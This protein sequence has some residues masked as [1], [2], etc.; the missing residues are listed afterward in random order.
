MNQTPTVLT[1]GA[2][3]PLCSGQ[4]LSLTSS[5]AAG[6][7]FNW[8]GPNGFSSTLQNPTI[9]NTT[10]LASGVYSVIASVSGCASATGTVSVLVNQTPIA[11]TA[12]GNSPI[13]SGQTL[14]LTSGSLPG[15][16]YSWSGPNSFTSTI[17]NPSIVNTTT[18]AS[19]VYSVFVTVSGC[20]SS[21]GTVN[22]VVNE[23]PSTPT[24]T[25][26]AP[27]CQGQTLFL[28]TSA[29]SGASY[30]WTGPNS[31]TSSIQNPTIVSTTTLEAGTYSLSITVLGCVSPTG[32]LNITINPTP[33]TPIA[34]SNAPLC[35]GQTLSLTAS[36]IFGANYSW[37][38]P[39][40]F[41][42]T[43]QN[44]V[45]TNATTS[46][47]GTYTV[48][49]TVAGCGSSTSTVSV[50]VSPLVI[51]PIANS[52]SPICEGQPILLNAGTIVGAT[53]N[54][55]GPNSFTSTVQNPSV[56]PT[57]TLSAGVYS[58]NA[59]VAGCTGPFGTVTVVVNPTPLPPNP[60]SNSPL[61]EGQTLLLT[62]SNIA[63]ATYNWSGP[64]SF[65]SSVQN[66]TIV[67]TTSLTAGV[68]TV[69]LTVGG[70]VSR[71][72]TINVIVNPLPAPVIAGANS[73][74]CVGATLSLT[75][76]NIIGATYSWNGPL[77]FTSAVQNPTIGGITL[78]ASGIYSVNV[79]VAGCTGSTG[80]VNVLVSPPVAAPVVGSNSPICEGQ[81]LFL[82]AGT[83]AGATY[84]WFGPNS[85]TS[86]VQNPTVITT[87][88]LSAGVYS[89]NA[90][91]AGCIGP[92]G[93]VTVIVNP[94]PAAPFPGS[95]S[96]ICAG[97]TLSLTTVSVAGATYSWTGPN[98]F[99]SNVQNPTISPTSTITSGTYTV[100]VNVGGCTSPDTTILVT[101]NPIPSAPT[102]TA[103]TPLCVNS[104]LSLTANSITGAVYNWTGPNSFTANIQNPT[105]PNA[106]TITVGVYS[107][108]IT[109]L[110]CTGPD[111]T[112]SVSVT[113]PAVVNAGPNDTICAGAMIITGLSGTITSGYI[114]QWTTL[115]S[116]TFTN[117]NSQTTDYNLSI[118]DTTAG[119]VTLVL[120]ATGGGCPDVSDTVVYTILSSP[121]VY[122]GADLNVCKNAVIPL[123]GIINGVTNTGFWISSGTGT[124]SPN[125]NSLIGTYFPSSSDTASNSIQL[126]L[127]ST[128][129]KGCLPDRD[130]LVV[131]FINAPKAS[132]TYTAACANLPI[133]F[134]NTSTPSLTALTH[135]WDFGDASTSTLQNPVH[136]FTIGG[137]YTVTLITTNSA[138]CPDTV[139]QAVPVFIAPVAK[140]TYS[141]VCVGTIG[142][143]SDSSTV[144]TGSITSW[145]WNFGDGGTSTIQ[146]PL[147]T[148]TLAGTYSVTLNV[149]SSNGCPG[150][151]TNIINVNPKPKADFSMSG[152]PIFA[153]ESV[154]FSD[155]STPTGS[156][157]TWNWQ[158]GDGNGSTVQNP[159]YI[160]D[161]KGFF[162]VQLA[163]I[164]AGG[165]ADTIR[166]DITV[167]LLPM[168]PTAFT[169]NADSHNDVLYVKGG[170]FK[171]M[172]FRVYN[173]W[174]EKLFESTKQEDGW[175]GNYK[176]DKVQ[177]GV[178]V[179]ILDVEMYDGQQIRKTGDVT[180]LK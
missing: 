62:A 133:F 130:T 98:T 91:V 103:N 49:V 26:N 153:N 172:Y 161:N 171:S 21:A 55:F 143:F 27:L 59:T 157:V 118:A 100:N 39:L 142:V 174:G 73:P 106:G 159:S 74:L 115:G 45:I 128:N 67:S 178:Y 164:D 180:I 58:V 83:I 60:G 165:C 33:A 50:L 90:N 1:I 148:Y 93:T 38:G 51:A 84:N 22:I 5:S 109:V 9:A 37:S 64:N 8:S 63:S 88:T 89:V 131:N 11:V 32:T 44:P 162:T 66:P 61:C 94:T 14:N 35:A 176:G 129:N 53:Y 124:F 80:T 2:N 99:T 97:Q 114:P 82:T 16:T 28:S 56:T 154:T 40:S 122:A 108:N 111:G 47:S 13:C 78:T 167:M 175:D 132:F 29:I 77:S 177:I 120:T 24:I 116:G 168:L 101:V 23:T 134:N 137:T 48:N 141:N 10:T 36:N 68:Y 158:Y 43:A 102:A 123:S 110:G 76:S 19:G 166:K 121:S 95:N 107:V 42:S 149:I 104:T 170:P 96:P 25:S 72:T 15:A 127:E 52:N 160:Y 18:L 3:S 85:F 138:G 155:L 144:S 92:F 151:T 69:N 117:P 145:N 119:T 135:S 105:I 20:T 150:T 41:T 81:P 70:C 79:T 152:N 12:S 125:S 65:T 113:E 156:I 54:W 173:S 163:I 126:I 140:F 46:M 7:T 34:G 86:T 169:P 4:T 139:R 57:T 179:W 146:N 17:Q 87:T 6:A 147:Y 112:V 75:A 30:N 71:D 136:T 31:F